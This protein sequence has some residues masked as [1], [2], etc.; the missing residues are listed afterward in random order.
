MA[1]PDARRMAWEIAEPLGESTVDLAA[2]QGHLLAQPLYAAVPLPSCDTAAMDGYAVAGDGPWTVV[3]RLVAGDRPRPGP[4]RPGQAVEIAT[5][6]PVMTGAAAV[7]PVERTQ[8]RGD[9]VTGRPGGRS[10]IRY[11]GEDIAGGAELLPEGAVVTPA[12]LGL[13]AGVGTDVLRVHRRPRVR[14]A[15][16]GDE[17]R[18][19]GRP[20]PG[21]VRDA[22]G[23]MLPGLIGCAGGDLIGV[24]HLADDRRAF[25]RM[26]TETEADVV[27]VSGSTSVGAADHLR[28]ALRARRADLHVD[29]VA[30]R[31]GHPQLLAGLS[32]G[33]YVVGLPGNPFAAL[34]AALTVL[35]PLLARLGSRPARPMPTAPLVPGPC[36]H[37]SDTVLV[38]AVWRGGTLEPVGR[39]RPGSLWGAALADAL[40]VLPP[41]RQ[42]S[43]VGVLTLPGG[44][45]GL[46]TE[47]RAGTL[48]RPL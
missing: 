24:D 37:P 10:H 23:P 43:D 15:V 13:A 48:P 3:G 31:P 20:E 7:L 39:D 29:G 26:L 9:I 27:V 44:S 14:V 41:G 19:H 35:E 42:G 32:D 22:I 16:T 12:V 8:R 25:D 5:G 11:R 38:A 46:S 2:A 28:A 1:W 33:R 40:A 18:R 30:C 6:A 4:L 34:V 17:L 21:Q 36:A 47:A 45:L